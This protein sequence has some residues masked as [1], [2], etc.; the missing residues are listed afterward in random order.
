MFSR[1]RRHLSRYELNYPTLLTKQILPVRRAH[2]AQ[3]L[4]AGAGGMR[5]L[6]TDADSLSVGGELKLSLSPDHFSEAGQERRPVNVRCKVVWQ[7]PEN[8]QIGLSYL[9]I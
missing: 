8:N 7:N 1:E 6:V 4:D 5:L 2:L 9:Y 3:I